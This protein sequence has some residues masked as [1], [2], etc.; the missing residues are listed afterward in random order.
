MNKD[1]Q[2]IAHPQQRGGKNSIVIQF[3]LS[4]GLWVPAG[5]KE[6]SRVFC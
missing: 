6:G 4:T 5:D 1:K 3:N 2:Q